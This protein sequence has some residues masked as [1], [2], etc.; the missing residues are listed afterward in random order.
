MIALANSCLM[1]LVMHKKWYGYGDC[2]FAKYDKFIMI[3]N[4]YLLTN[5]KPLVN[6]KDINYVFDGKTVSTCP[7]KINQLVSEVLL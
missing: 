6:I 5:D 4:K 2:N 1:I 7:I 3:Y